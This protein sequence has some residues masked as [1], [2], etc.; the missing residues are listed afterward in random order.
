MKLESFAN[1]NPFDELSRSTV[2][3][4]W[5]ALTMEVL[6]RLGLEAVVVSPGSRSTPLAIAARWW[7]APHG[8]PD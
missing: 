1:S 6:A 7:Q 5:G 3:S 4:A 8:L 2:N